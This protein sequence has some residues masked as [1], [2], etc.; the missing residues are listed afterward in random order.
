M[1]GLRRVLRLSDHAPAPQPAHF[2]FV[3]ALRGIAVLGVWLVHTGQQTIGLSPAATAATGFGGYGVQLFFVASA[4]TLFTSLSRRSQAEV[5]PILNYFLRRFF[6]IAPLFWLAIVFY[7]W[8]YGR[9]PHYW[10]PHGLGWRHVLSTVFFV[11]GW[12]P[13]TINS[14]VPGGWSIAVEMNFYLLVPLL[15]AALTNLR[16]AVWFFV[17]CAVGQVLL[18][19]AAQPWLASLA[20]PH[21]QYLVDLMRGLWLPAQ[22]PVFAAGFVLYYALAPRTARL[23]ALERVALVT[24]VIAQRWLAPSSMFWGSVFALLAFGLARRPVAFVVN[25]ATQYLGD[26]SY[27]GYLAHFA[28]IDLAERVLGRAGTLVQHPLAHVVVLYAAVAAGTVAVATITSRVI[29][30]P[31]RAAGRSLVAALER[32]AHAAVRPP[33]TATI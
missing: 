19:A 30:Q 7:V 4:F 13:D 31:A 27:S 6:R 10:S 9:G 23:P 8:W 12:A 28:V 26:I 22:M 32:R 5:R 20:A 25:R 11:H 17:A 14:V 1:Q 29:E 33:S 16:R 3:D 21:D 18:D 15:F 24:T 2:P